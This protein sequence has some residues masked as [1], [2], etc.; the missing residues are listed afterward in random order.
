MCIRGPPAP[1]PLPPDFRGPRPRRPRLDR[2]PPM[3]SNG[4]G[5]LYV[6]AVLIPLVAFAIQLLFG[7][8]LRERNAYVATGAIATSCVLSLLGFFGYMAASG[9]MPA[10]HHGEEAHAV[11]KGHAARIHHVGVGSDLA[12]LADDPAATLGSWAR[13]ERR[14]VLKDLT[15]ETDDGEAIVAGKM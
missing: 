14:Q 10:P 4:Q 7:R 9:G 12:A 13:G 8:V 2:D 15:F 1:R 6:A 3:M 5:W 11:E